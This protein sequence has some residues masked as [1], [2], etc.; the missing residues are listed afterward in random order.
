MYSFNAICD[1]VLC[2]NCLY[3]VLLGVLNFSHRPVFLGVETRCFKNWICF[4]PQEKGERRNL[5]SWAP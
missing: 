5:L 3:T 2:L 1:Y 4:C